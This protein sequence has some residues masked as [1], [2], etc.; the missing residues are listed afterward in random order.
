MAILTLEVKIKPGMLDDFK[1]WVVES[2]KVISK[3]DGFVS[4]RLLEST[5]GKHRMMV[6]FETEEQLKVMRKS[7]EHQ[8]VHKQGEQL[9]EAGQM[10]TMY[11]VIS[12]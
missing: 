4:R 6:E 3:F 9:R 2:N 5:D 12:G 1:K 7:P 8:T 10:P 11:R